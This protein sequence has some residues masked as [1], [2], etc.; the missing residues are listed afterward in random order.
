MANIHEKMLSITHHQG[1]TNQ[2]HTETPP[3]TVRMAKINN[4][5]K[6]R[7]WR[8][9]RERESLLRSWWECKVVQSLWKT[10]WRFLKKLKI[11]GAWVG[12]SVKCP[13]LAQVMIS[14]FVSSSPTLGSVL[15]AQYLVPDSDSVCVG[16][17]L[18]PP[19]MLSQK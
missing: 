16:V 9:C 12:Q 2:N 3:H 19:L 17:S 13:T 18:P 14:W 7:C 1:N 4:L 8:G 10:V 5:G 15:R 11:G 6:N